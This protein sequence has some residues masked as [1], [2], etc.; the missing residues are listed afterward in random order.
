MSLFRCFIA[1]LLVSILTSCNRQ[2]VI[3]ARQEAGPLPVRVAPVVGKEIQ[4]TVETVGSLF[5]FDE[6]II[7]AEVEGRLD[8]I[9][10]DLGDSVTQGQVLV[11]I[12]D[13]EQKYKLLQNEAQL[14]QSL[15]RLGLQ[16]EKDRVKDVKDT[17]DVRKAQADV[18]DAEQRFKRTRQLVEQGVGSQAD[19]DQATARYKAAQATYDA[20]INATRNLIQE[21][22]RFKA[23]LELQRKKLRDTSVRAPFNGLVKDR[24]AVLGA[25]VQVNSP[26]VPA[27]LLWQ[28]I[29]RIASLR[30]KPRSRSWRLW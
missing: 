23:A 30:L 14:R 20:T 3:E 21:V 16:S 18:F 10:V 28:T 15:E 11:H 13:E 4:R 29:L 6:A 17:P 9:S 12:N 1:V 27:N 8:G 7:S 5:P 22:E 26:L 25:Y 2:R 19:L 24:Q